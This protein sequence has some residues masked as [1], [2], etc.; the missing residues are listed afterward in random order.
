MVME[1]FV[2]QNPNNGRNDFRLQRVSNPTPLDLRVRFILLS[3]R[4]SYIFNRKQRLNAKLEMQQ[5][6]PHSKFLPSNAQ[7][8]K[9]Q[10]D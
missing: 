7:L 9:V 1:A 5:Q 6:G 10:D 8:L 4:G 3:Y 2:Q